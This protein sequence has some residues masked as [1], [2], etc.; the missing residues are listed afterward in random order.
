MKFFINALSLTKV[1]KQSNNSQKLA[2]EMKSIA[3]ILKKLQ[4]KW[5][6]L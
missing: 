3:T 6:T 2:T 1:E 5:K 4:W